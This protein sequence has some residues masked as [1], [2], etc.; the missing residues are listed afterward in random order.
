MFGFLCK[1]IAKGSP[2][3][4]L[5]HSNRWWWLFFTL[6]TSCFLGH[7]AAAEPYQEILL[8][9]SG[10]KPHYREVARDIA[11]FLSTGHP[12]VRVHTTTANTELP[13]LGHPVLVVAIGTRAAATAL[14]TYPKNPLL[15]LFVT[16]ASWRQL[17]IQHPAIHRQSA[18]IFIDQPVARFIYLAEILTPKTPTV[19]AVLG[20]SSRAAKDALVRTS[21]KRGITLILKDIDHQSNPLAVLTPL[22]KSSDVFIALPDEAVLSRSIAQWALHLGFK[23]KVPIIGFSRSYADAGAAASLYTSP[24]DIGRQGRAWIETYFNSSPGSLWG[25]FSPQFFS[26]TV[27]ASVAGILNLPV[28]DEMRIHQQLKRLELGEQEP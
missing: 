12:H 19:S 23:R 1:R 14:T 21:E 26:I 9:L 5:A 17:S 13:H 6:L 18:V 24:E 16:E 11:D 15:A 25:E 10:S 7:R 8:L 28:R 4:F 3:V 20:P 22:F 2:T 27:N